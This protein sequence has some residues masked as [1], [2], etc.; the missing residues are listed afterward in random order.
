MQPLAMLPEVVRTRPYLGFLCTVR[1]S[2]HVRFTGWDLMQALLVPVQVV[3]GRE[4]IGSI[5]AFHI[6]PEWFLVPKPMLAV[7][8]G[9]LDFVFSSRMTYLK[10]DRLLDFFW[11]TSQIKLGGYPRCCPAKPIE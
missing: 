3:L 9:K 11:Q 1:D 6:A 8:Y 2:A 10:S 5:A 7:I 4:T